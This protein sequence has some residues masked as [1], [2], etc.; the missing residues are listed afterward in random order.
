MKMVI[1][2]FSISKKF[3]KPLFVGTCLK[4]KLE[5]LIKGL[6]TISNSFYV[7]INGSLPLNYLNIINNFYY[8]CQILYN[9]HS[10]ILY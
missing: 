10:Y 5:V 6:Y 9:M 1:R 7:I 8:I 4:P 2:F 3:T